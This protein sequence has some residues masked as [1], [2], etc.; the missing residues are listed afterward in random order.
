M[1]T[2][3]YLVVVFVALDE[4]T[5][6]VRFGLAQ[7]VQ[8]QTSLDDVYNVDCTE[9][10]RPA[11]VR[12]VEVLAAASLPPAMTVLPVFHAFDQLSSPQ[13]QCQSVCRP[14]LLC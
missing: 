4:P 6:I 12:G 10:S 7:Y 9:L 11:I 2:F 1:R 3:F 13:R 14:N 8:S 5:N